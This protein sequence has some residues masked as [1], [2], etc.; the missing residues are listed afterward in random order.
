MRPKLL[1][2]PSAVRG[3]R[4][5]FVI[6]FEADAR[7]TPAFPVLA[8]SRDSAVSLVRELHLERGVDKQRWR[9]Y[10]C[11]RLRGAL[12][13]LVVNVRNGALTTYSTELER[14]LA[15]ALRPPKQRRRAA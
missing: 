6:C 12:E 1:G 14:E 9:E 13:H 8:A 10:K 7:K 11:E 4:A 15:S 3:A 5:P 2:D